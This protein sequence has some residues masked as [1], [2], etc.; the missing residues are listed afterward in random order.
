M[1]CLCQSIVEANGPHK[2]HGD[3]SY[4]DHCPIYCSVRVDGAV[5]RSPV[6]LKYYE[7]MH[8]AVA[9]S[10]RLRD[11]CPWAPCLPSPGVSLADGHQ[12]VV[13]PAAAGVA[14]A[15]FL[16]AMDSDECK[17]FRRQQTQE[18]PPT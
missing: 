1:A 16:V 4:D 3:P 13:T 6:Y 8:E 18:L 14:I 5:L 11:R 10:T 7:E 15:G 12:N 9:A 17:A 2:H